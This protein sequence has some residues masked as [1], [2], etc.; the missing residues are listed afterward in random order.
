MIQDILQKYIGRPVTSE[1]RE[2]IKLDVSKAMR[3]HPEQVKVSPD[4]TS[5]EVRQERSYEPIYSM[6][7]SEPI[8]FSGHIHDE[9]DNPWSGRPITKKDIDDTYRSATDRVGTPDVIYANPNMFNSLMQDPRDRGQVKLDQLRAKVAELELALE[10][11][12]QDVEHY[13]M[14]AL[15]N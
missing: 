14:L 11:S 15:E 5:V 8:G 7:R 1:N 12:Q 4:C 3:V 9:F 6:G 2:R 13:K 10:Q